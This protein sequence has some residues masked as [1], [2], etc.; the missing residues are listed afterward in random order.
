MTPPVIVIL[1]SG[2]LVLAGGIMVYATAASLKL[3]VARSAFGP[4]LSFSGLGALI[5][6]AL[7]SV[8]APSAPFLLTVSIA[9]YTV[10]CGDAISSGLKRRAGSVTL[11]LRM[12]PV[13]ESL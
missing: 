5:H 8:F 11:T 1:L 13:T 10:L 6:K 4:G 2:I 9:D 3:L 12:L 7:T